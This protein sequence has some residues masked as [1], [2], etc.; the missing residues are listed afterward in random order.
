MSRQRTK[1]QRI[2]CCFVARELSVGPSG[3]VIYDR[4]EVTLAD[5]EGGGTRQD[6]LQ[7]LS[8]PPFA[9]FESLEVNPVFHGVRLGANYIYSVRLRRLRRTRGVIASW[10]K[11]CQLRVGEVFEQVEKKFQILASRAFGLVRIRREVV[12]ICL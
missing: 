9:G 1:W 3:G 12:A 2:R 11:H 7:E 4:E 5:A 8:L 10:F 6:L